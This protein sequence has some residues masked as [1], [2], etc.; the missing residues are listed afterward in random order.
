MTCAKAQGD[1]PRRLHHW[2]SVWSKPQSVV[3]VGC[4]H[5]TWLAVFVELGILEYCGIYGDYIDPSALDIPADRFIAA[6]SAQPLRLD[7]RFDL[8]VTLEVAEH[9]PKTDASTFVQSLT[10]LGPVVLFSA[11]I[12]FQGGENHLNEQWPDYWAHLF[13]NRG[14]R[15]VD[16]LRKKTWHNDKVEPWYA[17]N[18]LLFVH[19][20]EIASSP[21]LCQLNQ[22]EAEIR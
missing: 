17:Q 15:A 10:E 7:R 20:D 6:D 11:A 22:R 18:I 2:S 5:G 3:D 9:L 8:V 19:P 14:Y 4:G 21:R 13:H 1:P 16:C 12:P